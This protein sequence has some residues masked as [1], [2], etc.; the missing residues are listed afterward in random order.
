M[1]DKK[2][3]IIDADYQ[4]I[5][6]VISNLLDNAFKFTKELNDNGE[7][8]ITIEEMK[9]VAGQQYIIIN[10]HDNGKGIESKYYAPIVY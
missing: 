6:Q 10:I 1:L 4:R 7:I 8:Y 5:L 2:T 3:Y 9:Q